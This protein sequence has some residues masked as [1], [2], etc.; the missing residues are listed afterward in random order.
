M[1]E[2][3][4]TDS[5]ASEAVVAADRIRYL[6]LAPLLGENFGFLRALRVLRL[7]RLPLLRVKRPTSGTRPCHAKPEHFRAQFLQA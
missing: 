3:V 4:I 7:L 2:L 6:P 1:R 5:I